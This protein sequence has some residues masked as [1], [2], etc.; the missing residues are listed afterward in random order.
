MYCL[1][2]NE[3]L[4]LVNAYHT[5]KCAM[6]RI[7]AAT[8]NK[9]APAEWDS[10]AE[11][12]LSLGGCNRFRK[13]WQITAIC[14]RARVTDEWIIGLGMP[15][16]ESNDEFPESLMLVSGPPLLMLQ[17]ILHSCGISLVEFSPVLANTTWS[18]SAPKWSPPEWP[19]LL[20]NVTL[21]ALRRL[22]FICW[23]PFLLRRTT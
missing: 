5:T 17:I 14:N 2:T 22:S 1:C 4:Q 11:L 21:R 19:Y 3:I 15:S 9:F 7:C 6:L 8:T 18:S 10:V 20:L 12:K 13:N 16:S 23:I